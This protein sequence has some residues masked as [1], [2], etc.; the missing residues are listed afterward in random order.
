M[1][2]RAIVEDVA[3]NDHHDDEDPCENQ[4]LEIQHRCVDPAGGQLLQIPVVEREEQ[5]E[6]Q[7]RIAADN[8]DFRAD[9]APCSGGGDGHNQSDQPE[10]TCAVR[11]SVE[12]DESENGNQRQRCGCPYGVYDAVDFGAGFRT[13]LGGKETR[14]QKSDDRNQE[15]A[16]RPSDRAAGYVDDVVEERNGHRRITP[17]EERTA[18]IAAQPVAGVFDHA[19]DEGQ[20]LGG[21]GMHVVHSVGNLRVEVRDSSIL[22]VFVS[23]DPVV[24]KR[25][26]QTETPA[27]DDPEEPPVVGRGHSV[28]ESQKDADAHERTCVADEAARNLA[29]D[30]F[31]GRFCFHMEGVLRGVLFFANIK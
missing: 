10:K 8:V 14:Q 4:N 7:S 15:P 23:A 26:C 17:D 19:V 22:F 12:Q 13:F 20:A 24:D 29:G 31:A 18:R 11:Q 21:F 3:G 16:P 5:G 25:N 28:D 6:N 1:A 9:D 30:R 2:V 27:G